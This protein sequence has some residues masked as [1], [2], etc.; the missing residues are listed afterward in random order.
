LRKVFSVNDMHS[1]AWSSWLS[2]HPSCTGS[3]SK[4]HKLELQPFNKLMLLPGAEQL[5]LPPKGEHQPGR[6][7]GRDRKVHTPPRGSHTCGSAPPLIHPAAR[8]TTA[9]RGLKKGLEPCGQPKPGRLAWKATPRT[10]TIPP[11]SLK[12]MELIC[13]VD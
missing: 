11:Q 4:N 6:T 1:S 3:D 2:A 13:W 9:R 8:P 10:K 5:K 12:L 7:S